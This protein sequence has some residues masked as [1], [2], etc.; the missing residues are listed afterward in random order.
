MTNSYLNV[1]IKLTK[2]NR[3]PKYIFFQNGNLDVLN[4][5]LRV[6]GVHLDRQRRD[7]ASPLWI[8]C[9][10][11]HPEIVASLLQAGAQVRFIHRYT[12]RYIDK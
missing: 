10:T 8:A 9:Q 11:G 1:L 6:P 12:D 4:Q 2:P 5:L 7:G 3:I